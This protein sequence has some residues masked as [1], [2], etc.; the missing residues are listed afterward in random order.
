MCERACCTRARKFD[1]H[2]TDQMSKVCVNKTF[3]IKIYL[4]ISRKLCLLNMN[5]NV[6]LVLLAWLVVQDVSKK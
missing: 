3:K 2:V 1:I 5:L 4:I 6:V